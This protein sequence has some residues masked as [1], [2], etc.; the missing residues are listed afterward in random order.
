MWELERRLVDFLL[1]LRFLWS[2]THLLTC[3]QE[4]LVSELGLGTV[5]VRSTTSFLSA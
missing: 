2:L 3:L 5:Q 1:L 4:Y